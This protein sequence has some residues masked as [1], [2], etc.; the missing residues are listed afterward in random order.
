MKSTQ[1]KPP[2]TGGPHAH[3]YLTGLTMA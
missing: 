3:A 2:H 1:P